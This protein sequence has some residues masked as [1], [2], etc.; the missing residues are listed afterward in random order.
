MRSTTEPEVSRGA[1]RP[2]GVRETFRTSV[3]QL[4]IFGGVMYAITVTG[5]VSGPERS[6][7]VLWGRTRKGMGEGLG[8]WTD[9]DRAPRAL[10]GSPAS[11]ATH[12]HR[13]DFPPHADAYS[14]RFDFPPQVQPPTTTGSTF[15]RMPTLTRTGTAGP[16]WAGLGGLGQRGAGTLRKRN[17]W[18][19]IPAWTK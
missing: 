16:G 17:S 15:P 4:L 14:N 5:P 1:V 2:L 3:A 8:A 12:N 18:A 11:P 9:K 7:S 19:S 6:P 13:F 10:P